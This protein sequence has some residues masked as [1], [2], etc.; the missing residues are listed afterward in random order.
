MNRNYAFELL[1]DN[2]SSVAKMLGISASAVYKWPEELPRSIADKVIAARIRL[3]WW[4]LLQRYP[5]AKLTPL[6]IE[7]LKDVPPEESLG[8]VEIGRPKAVDELQSA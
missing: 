5:N 4:T 2:R 1:G 3:E 8:I 7:I 6:V